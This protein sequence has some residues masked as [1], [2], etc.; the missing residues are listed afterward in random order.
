MPMYVGM[1]FSSMLGARKCNRT[2]RGG[3]TRT[4]ATVKQMRRRGQGICEETTVSSPNRFHCEEREDMD[5]TDSLDLV[6]T[7]RVDEVATLVRRVCELALF[8][9]S[10]FLLRV[11]STHLFARRS[12]VGGRAQ[13][14]ARGQQRTTVNKKRRKKEQG[15]S[16]GPRY[17]STTP[18]PASAL[19]HAERK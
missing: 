14:R 9:A 6:G 8:G 18:R 7:V 12:R 2:R 10:Q 15:P 17:G 1:S 13:T 11:G 3:E 16:A 4:R 5:R 19:S